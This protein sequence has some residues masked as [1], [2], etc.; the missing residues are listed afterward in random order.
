MKKNE[1]ESNDELRPEYNL[2]SLRVRKQGTGRRQLAMREDLKGQFCRK[3]DGER[4]WVEG[5]LPAE[6]NVPETAIFIYFEGPK[7]GERG[8]GP[9]TGLEPLGSEIPGDD[10]RP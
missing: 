10:A 1:P 5:I 7:K 6:G 2:K 8:R 4:V 9:T 3:P